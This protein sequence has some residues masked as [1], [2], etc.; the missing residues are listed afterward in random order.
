MR[1]SIN[2]RDAG[3]VYFGFVL[4]TAFSSN[5]QTSIPIGS[6]RLHLSYNNILNVEVTS[7]K[8]F[9]ASESGVLVFDRQEKTLNTFN[10]LTGLSSTGISSLDYDEEN[11]QLL[12]GYA[13]GD[14]DIIHE[15]TIANFSRLKE[16][17]VT[18]SKKINHIS[19]RENLAYLSTAYGVVLFDVQQLEIKETWRDLGPSGGQLHVYQSSFLNDSIF[20]ATD[21]GVIAGNMAD[22]LLDY[23]KW[24]RYN[25]G[26][27]SGTIQAIVSFNNKIY[28]AGPTGVYRIGDNTWIQEPFLQTAVIK[29]LTASAENLFMITDSAIWSM[30][31]SGELSPIS[32]GV[33]KAPS[34]VKQDEAGNFWI[35]DQS[36]GLVSNTAGTFSSYLPNG[37]SLPGAFRMVYDNGK[38]YALSGGF[39]AS[40]QPSNIPGELNIF[41]NGNWSTAQQPVSDLTDFAIR[42]RKTFVA[43]FGSGIAVSDE[44]GNTVLLDETNSPLVNIDP[45]KSSITALE[46]SADGLWVANYGGTLPLH[47]FKNDGSWDSYSF[48]FSNEQNPIDLSVDGNGD[49]WM[50]LNPNSGGGLIAFERVEKQG[51]YKTNVSGSGALPDRNVRCVATDRDGY[52]WV[53][54]DAGVAYFFSASED[55]I[56]P[57]YDTRFLLR[58]EK[59]TALSVDGGNRK[60]IGTEQGVWLFTATGEALVHHF[61]SENSPLLSN[62]IRDIQ[63]DSQTGEVFFGTDKGIISYRSDAISAGPDFQKLKIFPNPVNPGYNGTV[64]ISGL[65]SDAH[66]RI[67]DISGR[68]IWQSQANGGMATWN[69]R[70]HRGKRASTGIYLVFAATQDGTESMVGKIAVIE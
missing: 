11:D 59:I 8:V 33:I 58:D 14:L 62:I 31:T 2:P 5:A 42:D 39:S 61:T 26:D 15:N 12:V 29:S 9:A 3:I 36:A 51:H 24:T 66:V 46:P 10:K 67:T 17:D 21:N 38:L 37:P 63:I 25:A 55:A 16:S 1:R 20:L 41:E 13:D 44:A 6:W 57:V 69:V 64:G 48:N 68:L 47:L 18:T 7:E 22:N 49:V 4:I 35:G 27:L 65:A 34:T 32:D 23:N 30:N 56:K 43:S 50:V 52:T 53:G 40:G 70:D 54:T 45:V 60:W 28:A 19:M